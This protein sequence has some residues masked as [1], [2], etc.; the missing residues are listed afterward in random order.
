MVNCPRHVTAEN[1]HLVLN[2]YHPLGIIVL[3]FSPAENQLD[4]RK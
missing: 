3:S 4:V 1:A 2:N